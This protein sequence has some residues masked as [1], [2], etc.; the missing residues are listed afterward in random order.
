MNR[1]VFLLE[2][3]SMK[4]LLE[5]LLPRLFP[6]LEFLCVPHQGKQDLEKSVPRKLR[7]WQEPGVRFAVLRDNDGG[8]CTVLKQRLASLCAEADR[9]DT[10]VR[11]PC[12]ELEAWYFG[13]PEAL[14]TAFDD[15]RLRGLGAKARFRQPDAV[16]A[17]S[18]ALEAL[19][20]AFQ[21]VSGARRLAP[22]LDVERS[23]SRSFQVFVSGVARV[24]EILKEDVP[25]PD[26]SE[27]D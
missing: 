4:V 11:I 19:I 18:R 5:G 8:D 9:P 7:A 10:L 16:D 27:G 12:Q 2:E 14:A 22:H 25:E 13:D 15:E 24:A 21:K 6:R 3:Y 26:T 17:P 1:L 23:T 20:P